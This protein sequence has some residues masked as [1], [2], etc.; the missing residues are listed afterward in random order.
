M[1]NKR[2]KANEKKIMFSEEV[3]N[4]IN[5]LAIGLSFVTI[6]L[7]WTFRADYFGNS[8]ANTIVQW[9][10]IVLGVLGL[11]TDIP[12]ILKKNGI[13]GTDDLLYGGLFFGIWLILFL[14]VSKTRVNILSFFLLLFG[15]YSLLKGIGEV[16]YSL[17]SISKKDSKT[18][19]V[20]FKKLLT[21]IVLLLT[22][23]AGFILVIIQ[24]IKALK[25][26][27]I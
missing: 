17:I 5:S 16:F 23:L 8:I 27:N 24:I 4:L 22:Q 9:C 7:I 25:E 11:A 13:Q 2:K 26:L 19:R 1:K 12:K 18:N 3:D 21:N 10:F 15:L 14:F 20:P 6:G